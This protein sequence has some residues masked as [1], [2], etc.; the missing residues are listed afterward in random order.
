MFSVSGGSEGI[1]NKLFPNF[2]TSLGN[3]LFQ[4]YHLGFLHGFLAQLYLI[5]IISCAKSKKNKTKKGWRSFT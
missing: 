3:I 1:L 5:S 4:E 2:V